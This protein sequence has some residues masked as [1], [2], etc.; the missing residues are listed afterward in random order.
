MTSCRNQPRH[1][2]HR[3]NQPAAWLLLLRLRPHVWL[4]LTRHSSNSDLPLPL[5]QLQQVLRQASSLLLCRS[6]VL[7]QRG[8]HTPPLS[9]TKEGA[10]LILLL[11]CLSC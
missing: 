3:C 9:R 6:V 2:R 4:P 5:L 8:L 1:R 11:R 10:A 7:P